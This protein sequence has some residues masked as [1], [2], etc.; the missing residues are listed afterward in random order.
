M[1]PQWVKV[2]VRASFVPVWD[3]VKLTCDSGLLTVIGTFADR[4][5]YAIELN[6]YEELKSIPEDVFEV[7]F[8]WQKS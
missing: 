4:I 6:N 7:L 5:L 2:R 1:I 3:V 8:I